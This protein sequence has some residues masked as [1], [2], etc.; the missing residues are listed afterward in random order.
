L[1][2]RAADLATRNHIAVF[3]V[4]GWWKDDRSRDRSA[5]LVRYAL[6]VSIETEAESTDVYTPVAN[7]IETPVE[8]ET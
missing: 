4:G 7:A 2:G 3:P 5:S 6:V 1:E 8:I